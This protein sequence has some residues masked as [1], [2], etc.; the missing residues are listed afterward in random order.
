MDKHINFKALKFLFHKL[1]KPLLAGDMITMVCWTLCNVYN[2]R[3]LGSFASDIANGISIIPKLKIYLGLVILWVACEYIADVC[4]DSNAEDVEVTTRKHYIERMYKCKPEILRKYNTGYISGMVDKLAFARSNVIHLLLEEMPLSAIYLIAICF[5][6]GTAYHWIYAAVIFVVSVTAVTFR[7]VVN[8]HN[9]K[10]ISELS[11][12]EAE[13]VQL[14]IDSGT[15]V[16]TVQKLQAMNFI[17]TKF[18]TSIARC[19]R[20]VLEFSK[21]H[22]LGYMGFKL[23]TYTIFPICAYIQLTHPET[24]PD[25]VGFYAFLVMIQIRIMHMIRSFSNFLKHWSKYKA[26]YSKLEAIL[27]QDNMRE[28]LSLEQFQKAEIKNCDYVY[29]YEDVNNKEIRKTVRVQIPYF[30]VEKGDIICIHGESGQGKT[31]LLNILSGEIET[32]N[33]YINDIQTTKRLD[34]VFVAQDTEIFDMTIRDNLSLGNEDVSDED[35]YKMF[36]ATGLSDWIK[37]QPERLNT[38]LG[39][40][41]VFVSTGQRQRLN[42][43]RGLVIPYGEIYFFDEPTS[44]VDGETEE[45]MI[46]LIQEKLKGKTAIIV[47]HKPNIMRICNKSYKFSQGVLSAE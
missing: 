15:N 18:N 13:N 44:N 47:T 37:N 36:D 32:N 19:R 29:E 14:F 34:C 26:P 3:L 25:V 9:K 27:C 38:R 2:D 43:I 17:N 20:A 12:S 10:R 4:I 33:V 28:S 24:A 39:E 35:I 5:I 31:T 16:N 1:R 45:K 42:L 46:S 8:V 23:I 40:R 11:E 21:V 41:G 7:I 6:M 30:K 22:E